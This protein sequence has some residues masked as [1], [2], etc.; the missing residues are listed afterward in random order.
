MGEHDFY[1]EVFH[2]LGVPYESVK[3]RTDVNPAGPASTRSSRSR[4]R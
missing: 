3:W 1:D 4:C 2:S